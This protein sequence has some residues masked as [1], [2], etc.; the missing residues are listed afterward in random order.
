M[1]SERGEGFAM[2]DM[3]VGLGRQSSPE[4]A[5]RILRERTQERA[6]E[7]QRELE[8]QRTDARRRAEVARAERTRM[9]RSA[10]LGGIIDT[11]A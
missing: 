2:P 11:T 10:G 3:I 4:R 9:A 6:V 7:R 8:L 1:V 5:I